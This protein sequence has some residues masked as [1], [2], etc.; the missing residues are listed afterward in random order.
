MPA[1]LIPCFLEFELWLDLQFETSWP[2]QYG[3]QSAEPVKTAGR[4]PLI[5][6]M[7]RGSAPGQTGRA[8]KR[9][10]FLADIKAYF[11]AT[12]LWTHVN[13]TVP[14]R[15]PVTVTLSPRGLVTLLCDRGLVNLADRSAYSSNFVPG[16][17]QNISPPRECLIS[18]A[19][20]VNENA[21]PRLRNSL[22]RL[23]PPVP[24]WQG[25]ARTSYKPRGNAASCYHL[26]RLL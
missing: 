24:H 14:S 25:K 1:S 16:G 12:S 18:V 23:A 6:S 13:R 20:T 2:L 9:G 11:R 8:T 22:V 3:H 21:G 15:D 10:C 5:P 17:W 4:F 26:S 7:F 19:R